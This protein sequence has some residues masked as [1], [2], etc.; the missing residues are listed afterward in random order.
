MFESTIR[1]SVLH[2]QSGVV[3][4]LAGKALMNVDLVPSAAL[5]IISVAVVS[6]PSWVDW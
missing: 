2:M 4:P 1:H 6:I 5:I 3:S